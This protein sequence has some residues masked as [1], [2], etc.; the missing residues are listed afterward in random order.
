MRACD[1]MCTWDASKLYIRRCGRAPGGVDVVA[2]A[3]LP[4]E[5]DDRA[6]RPLCTHHHACAARTGSVV[7]AFV[8]VPQQ[9]C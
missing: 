3:W 8:F 5:L 7:T 4:V 6:R 2:G 1:A 9:S